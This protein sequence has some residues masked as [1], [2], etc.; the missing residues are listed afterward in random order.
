MNPSLRNYYRDSGLQASVTVTFLKEPTAGTKVT[1]D[2]VEYIYGT[3]FFARGMPTLPLI[4]EGLCAAINADRAK[5]SQHTQTNPIKSVWAMYYGNVVRVIASVPGTVGNAIA[6]TTDEASSFSLSGSV[7]SGGTNGQSTAWAILSYTSDGTPNT[8]T[9]LSAT[10]LLVS[11][12]LVF[13]VAANTDNVLVG[14]NSSATARTVFPSTEYQ[15]PPVNG[16][17][18]NLKDWYA[19]SA[20]ASQALSIMY[21]I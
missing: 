18:F 3:T 10:D 6:I 15:I 8:P 13:G 7:L 20:T 2:G 17:T 4:A 5:Q 19:Q 1:I 14:P 16:R 12:A 11:T 9:R 21:I